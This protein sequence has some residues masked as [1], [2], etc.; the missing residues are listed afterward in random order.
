MS[1]QQPKNL[2]HV[3]GIISF[4]VALVVD[5]ANIFWSRNHIKRELALVVVYINTVALSSCANELPRNLFK[6]LRI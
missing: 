1:Q 4:V 2:G 5:T 3:A 6:A